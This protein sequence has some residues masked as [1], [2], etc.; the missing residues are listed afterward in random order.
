MKKEHS[1]H[2]ILISR[3]NMIIATALTCLGT[4]ERQNWFLIISPI[5]I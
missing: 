2:V 1:E 4:N 5:A 3:A